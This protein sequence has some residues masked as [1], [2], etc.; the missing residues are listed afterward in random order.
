MKVLITGATDG[1][2]LALARDY[3]R[4]GAQVLATGRRPEREARTVLPREAAYA[5]AD[6]SDPEA[7]ARTIGRTVGPH[8]DVAILNAGT[9]F[10]GD[11]AEDRR[12]G[13][14]VEVNLVATA[15]LARAVAPAILAADGSL[16]LVGSTAR[17]NPRFAAY[18]ASK[19][20]LAGLARS[21]AEEW[22][23]RAHVAALHPGPT[24]T[25][26]HEKAGLVVGP[27]RKLFLAPETVARGIE[28]AVRNR[29]SSRDLSRLYC[30]AARDP[31][32]A[33][34]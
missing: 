2:G 23:G 14:Q 19:A 20:G 1:I 27:V 21:L 7:V 33:I 8:L 15:L 4:A 34:A 5:Q 26:M 32:A 31:L 9:G 11:P 29:S 10:V 6:Q 18:G 13:E 3:A 17:H 22:R 12:V 24:A 25:A 16:V 28:R 30:L